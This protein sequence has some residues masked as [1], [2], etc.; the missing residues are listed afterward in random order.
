MLICGE[1]RNQFAI[2]AVVPRPRAV[3]RVKAL[4]FK[5]GQRLHEKIRLSF[6]E[7]PLGLEGEPYA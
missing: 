5:R 3:G 6:R 4:P 7:G 1:Q 2:T